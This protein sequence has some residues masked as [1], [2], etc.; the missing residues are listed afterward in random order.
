MSTILN[1]A[2]EGTTTRPSV[3]SQRSSRLLVLEHDVDHQADSY[4]FY[5]L[6]FYWEELFESLEI[7]IA[8]SMLE[9]V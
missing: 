7:S 4:A 6:E 8:D 9:G 5:A 3:H 1:R 2:G